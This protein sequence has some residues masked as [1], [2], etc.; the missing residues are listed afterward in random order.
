MGSWK[1][2]EEGS[3]CGTRTSPLLGGFTLAA[4]TDRFL[5]RT[6]LSAMHRDWRAGRISDDVVRAALPVCWIRYGSTLE[7]PAMLEM[8]RAVGPI[9]D[10]ADRPMPSR[11]RIYQGRAATE[12][13]GIAWSPER[14]VAEEYGKRWQA[15]RKDRGANLPAVLWTGN[16]RGSDVLM[17]SRLSSQVIVPPAA[18]ADLHEI[19]GPVPAGDADEWRSAWTDYRATLE[20]QAA[21]FVRYMIWRHYPDMVGAAAETVT[22]TVVRGLSAEVARLHSQIGLG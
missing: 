19:R 21:G 15:V 14:R 20:R 16:V 2:K 7:A 8:L 13:V 1:L 4:S 17:L 5:V 3:D 10:S 18:V 6:E 22:Q 9:S 11:F 12:P